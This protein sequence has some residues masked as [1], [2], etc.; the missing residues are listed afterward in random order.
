MS[1]IKNLLS[2]MEKLMIT[3]YNVDQRFD[4]YE[5]KLNETVYDDVINSY[6]NKK[7]VPSLLQFY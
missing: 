1:K 3:K 6:R 4:K 7:N 2:K 5:A